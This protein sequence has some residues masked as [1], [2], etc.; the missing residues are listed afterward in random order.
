MGGS[1]ELIINSS[2]DFVFCPVAI[3]KRMTSD[4]SGAKDR[5]S[6]SA[7]C[8]LYSSALVSTGVTF[9]ISVS[10]KDSFISS[11]YV[12]ACVWGRGG[13]ISRVSS[14]AHHY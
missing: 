2:G 4:L 8:A 1:T 5:P 13:L 10:A 14:C 12:T 9:P 7:L 6:A 11:T 3:D